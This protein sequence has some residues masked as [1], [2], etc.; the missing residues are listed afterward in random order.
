MNEEPKKLSEYLRTENG[1]KVIEKIGEELKELGDMPARKK[2]FAYSVLSEALFWLDECCAKCD[3]GE[4]GF[5]MEVTDDLFGADV[6][7][8]MADI[9]GWY[10]YNEDASDVFSDDADRREF[11]LKQMFW[12]YRA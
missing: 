1:E 2:G 9:R 11:A 8:L 12:D 10:S 4:E 7:S 5:D 3:P 6:E